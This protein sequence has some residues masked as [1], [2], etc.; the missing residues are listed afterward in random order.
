M[1]SKVS[2]CISKPEEIK[3]NLHIHL[4]LSSSSASKQNTLVLY[5]WDLILGQSPLL[6]I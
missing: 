5:G 2:R 6:C 3:A 4:Y 1:D